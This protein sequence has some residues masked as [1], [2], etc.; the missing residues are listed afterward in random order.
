MNGQICRILT[1]F[2]SSRSE[3]FIYV[4]VCN[5]QATY[6]RLR[7]VCRKRIHRKPMVIIK[8][9]IITADIYESQFI[10]CLGKLREYNVKI[11][12]LLAED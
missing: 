3:T 11:S 1:G 9:L 7:N 2:S 12:F 8:D 5:F 6:D 10:N 4:D